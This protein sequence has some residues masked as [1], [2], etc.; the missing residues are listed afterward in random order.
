MCVCVCVCV[1][2]YTSFCLEVYIRVFV[3]KETESHL[4]LFFSRDLS[5]NRLEILHSKSF[6]NPKNVEVL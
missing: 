4:D 1:E 5:H 2:A 3:L 6:L